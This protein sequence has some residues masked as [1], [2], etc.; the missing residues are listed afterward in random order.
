MVGVELDLV[1]GGMKTGLVQ[2]LRRLGQEAFQCGKILFFESCHVALF[3]LSA[4][5]TRSAS[6][7]RKY[8]RFH[9]MAIIFF[10]IQIGM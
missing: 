6:W 2:G 7:G 8:L 1:C 3:P 5:A 9:L 4:V 10:E